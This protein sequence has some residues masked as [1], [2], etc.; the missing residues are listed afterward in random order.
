MKHRSSIARSTYWNF[1]GLA[2]PLVVA[3]F[4]IP[5]LIKGLG[6]E[7]FGI[8]TIGWVIMGYFVLF[9]FGMGRATTK[10]LAEYIERNEFSKLPSLVWGSLFAHVI[11]GLL[12]GVVLAWLVPWFTEELFNV[13]PALIPE[14]KAAFY[15]LALSVPVVVCAA[16]FR[17][18]L[19]AVH[20][21]DL[22]N[23]VKIPSSVFN[24]L[25]PVAVLFFTRDLAAVI[26]LIVIGRIIALLALF[27]LCLKVLPNLWSN[28]SFDP[29]VVKPL[30]G[31]G[32]W[33]TISNLVTPVIVLM[34]RFIIGAFLS[35]SAVAYYVV[36]YEVVT[37]LWI[38]SASLLGVMF[39]VFSALSVNPGKEIRELCV[40]AAN[41]LM[42]AVSPIVAILVAYS[43]ELLDLWIGVDFAWQSASV[44]QWLAVGVFINVLAQVP[45]AA[46]QG[47]GRAD[48]PAKLQLIQLPLYAL[49]VV[50]LVGRM[51]IVGVAI[52]WTLRAIVDMGLLSLAAEKL[53]PG[54]ESETPALPLVKITSVFVAVL[55][56]G[57]IGSVL[58]GNPLTK[59]AVLFALILLF[60]SGQW[61]Y[62][63]SMSDR[64]G[65]LGAF[66]RLIRPVWSAR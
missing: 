34:D 26:G 9:D 35:M 53:L 56:F 30:M 4:A 60:V 45:F 21:F 25:G 65:L 64:T 3:L 18:I 61:I 59:L 17:G 38:F 39:P 14:V 63:L 24:Y 23:A 11:L 28:I 1:L 42:L 31:F 27:L 44:A 37:K 49:A 7:R 58:S 6:T 20:R 50:Y 62:V 40:R 52:V 12:G 16:C 15:L 54:A 29:V 19:E 36:P 55:I 66:N 22:V 13:P 51:G 41:Y 10:F 32:G 5:P 48:V 43:H 57:A 47:I 2:L 46:L 33:L 8:L